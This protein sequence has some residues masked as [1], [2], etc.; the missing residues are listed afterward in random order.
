VPRPA[1]LKA[2]SL[3]SPAVSSAPVHPVGPSV[4]PISVPPGHYGRDATTDWAGNN[5]AT[6]PGLRPE[7]RI[8]R[9]G[10]LEPTNQALRVPTTRADY[11]PV[12][13]RPAETRCWRCGTP[14]GP[15]AAFC[16]ACGAS[17]RDAGAQP[18]TSAAP[19]ARL[20][21]IA[22]DGTAGHEYPVMGGQ[23]DIGRESGDVR[24]STDGYACPRHARLTWKQGSFWVSDLG[25]VNGVFVRLTGPERL[26]HGDVLLLGMGVLR[27]EIVTANETALAPAI[28][29]GTR[30][31]GSPATP[32]YARL[33]ERT[34]EGV[35]RNVLYLSK[36]VVTIG[37]ET[38]DIVFTDDPF[39]SRQHAGLERQSD[40]TFIIKDL[41]SSNGTFLAIR[42]ERALPD[43]SHIRIGQHLFRLKI[44]GM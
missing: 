43:G 9:P 40:G 25:S 44:D 41:G 7:V 13:V 19:S 28:E 23:I 26:Q 37:R 20:I 34:V 3:A 1:I 6:D 4:A 33:V 36:N 22:Q 8:P 30:L 31:F 10:G 11:Q 2:T 16:Q 35:A 39:M 12:S 29:R 38:G 32:R 21:V 15:S 5:P 27:F 42:G 14:C 17:L 24:I 18:I